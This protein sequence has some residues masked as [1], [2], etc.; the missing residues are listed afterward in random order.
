MPKWWMWCLLLSPL[1]LAAQ[2]VFEAEALAFRRLQG[3]QALVQVRVPAADLHFAAQKSRCRAFVELQVSC[4]DEA[5]NRQ[6]TWL[7]PH[8]PVLEQVEN[9]PLVQQ[10]FV[11][12][13]WLDLPYGRYTLRVDARDVGGEFMAAK[14]LSL[15]F[16]PEKAIVLTGSD[17]LLSANYS[18][19]F[20]R[21]QPW[22]SAYLPANTPGM[23]W[24]V[25]LESPQ[26]QPVS[27][28]ATI[29]QKP[30][31][32]PAQVAQ[33]YVSVQQYTETVQ[34]RKG[35]N[36]LADVLLTEQLPP[37]EYLLELYA[38]LDGQVLWRRRK[39]F[40]LYWLGLD[41]LLSDRALAAEWAVPALGRYFIRRLETSG[42]PREELANAWEELAARWV[43]QPGVF[44]SAWYYQ[45]AQA[46]SEYG[47]WQ[48]APFQTHQ[49]FGM[50]A[51][52]RWQGDTEIWC[53]PDYD[54]VLGIQAARRINP[55]GE[56]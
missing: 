20:G 4:W 53:Y 40:S 52:R 14:R 36:V 55:Y 44:M 29:Y 13:Q 49:L 28:R 46:A 1:G 10:Y 48:G 39:A 21:L 35:R 11:L 34:L 43:Q 42:M 2:P 23:G 18:F 54:L 45:A 30:P 38:S 6:G 26:A 8:Q 32:S 24:Y 27:L 15:D 25:E 37:G 9:L 50:P 16:F 41:S 33:Q 12:Q 22:V 19:D 5:G 17:L 56:L 3:A 47:S 31:S 7:S 51:Q